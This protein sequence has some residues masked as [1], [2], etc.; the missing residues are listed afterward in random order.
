MVIP[1]IIPELVG[2]CRSNLPTPNARPKSKNGGGGSGVF[3]NDF[4]NWYFSSNYGIMTFFG[5]FHLEVLYNFAFLTEISSC[6]KKVIFWGLQC[7]GE[8]I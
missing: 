8:E 3:V 1:S 2:M 6:L 5:R 4:L 7:R